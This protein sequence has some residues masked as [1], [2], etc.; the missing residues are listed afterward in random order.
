M[1]GWADSDWS[2][3]C[4]AA[5]SPSTPRTPARTPGTTPSLPLVAY[6]GTYA[7]SLYG[8]LSITLEDDHLVL[9]YSPEYVADLEHW[10]HDT[11]RVHWRSIGFGSIMATFRVNSTRARVI[12]I[13]V[14]TEYTRHE[15]CIAI[16][17][18]RRP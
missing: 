7:D 16:N 6:E 17:S 2:R 3:I 10:H 14:F 15:P 5:Y 1:L 8:P 9:R 11:F 12:R 18:L 13:D 4:L